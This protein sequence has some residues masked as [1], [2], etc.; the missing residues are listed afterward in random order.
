MNVR[1]FGSCIYYF[2]VQGLNK[3][4]YNGQLFKASLH[5]P[6]LLEKVKNPVIKSLAE[7]KTKEIINIIKDIEKRIVF[8]MMLT[9]ALEEGDP[10]LWLLGV[11]RLALYSQGR[12]SSTRGNLA[13]N[14]FILASK[15]YVTGVSSSIETPL[16]VSGSLRNNLHSKSFCS[17]SATK[18]KLHPISAQ[19]LKQ[20]LNIFKDKRES[21]TRVNIRSYKKSLERQASEEDKFSHLKVFHNKHKNSLAKSRSHKEAIEHTSLQE[22]EEY[23]R[24]PSRIKISLRR[25]NS[26][27]SRHPLQSFLVTNEAY[28][29]KNQVKKRYCSGDFCQIFDS[30]SVVYHRVDE[31][32]VAL[33]RTKQFAPKF[34]TELGE[35]VFGSQGAKSLMKSE[36]ISIGKV[37]Q[38]V[39]KR[40]LA[41][42]E[43]LRKI[44]ECGAE[45]IR[46]KR[47]TQVCSSCLG[48]YT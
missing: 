13:S 5:S 35:L 41:D 44:P 30:C 22:S 46:S 28:N 29:P 24:T 17:K 3:S 2:N 25:R 47:I 6:N 9:F 20:Q 27:V 23:T 33:A 19:K 14:S 1:S 45:L 43:F 11:S 38:K 12:R 37:L 15:K 4:N 32:L 26:K 42:A 10:Q 18:I 31:L 7:E 34:N 21:R 39:R 40:A 16:L 36:A 8:G 48:A